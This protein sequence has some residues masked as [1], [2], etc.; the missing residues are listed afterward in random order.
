M[1]LSWLAVGLALA[2]SAP[3]DAGHIVRIETDIKPVHLPMGYRKQGESLS[4]SSTPI[5]SPRPTSSG[6]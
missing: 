3:A 5:S 2:L 1:R 4:Q 6:A